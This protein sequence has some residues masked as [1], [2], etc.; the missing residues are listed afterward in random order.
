VRDD[1]QRVCRTARHAEHQQHPFVDTAIG[2]CCPIA[3]AVAV[4]GNVRLEPGTE[5]GTGACLRNGITLGRG[6]M[7]G[8]GS[9]VVRD[10]A[11]RDLVVGNP[12][13]SIRQLE[14]F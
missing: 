1:D 10:V 11:A 5:V 13:R 9:V 7:A 6:S 2:E 8:M 3:P 12:A 14:A 4:S